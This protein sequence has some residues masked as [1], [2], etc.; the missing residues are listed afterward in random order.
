T[1]FL[2][3]SV[4][5]AG[6]LSSRVAEFSSSTG[7]QSYGTLRRTGLVPGCIRW[8]TRRPTRFSAL[9]LA[10]LSHPQLFLLLVGIIGSLL[11]DSGPGCSTAGASG[12]VLAHATGFGCS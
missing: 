12:G 3:R 7:Q 6:P 1:A 9:A 4:R 10:G 8:C 11:A 5:F 2:L